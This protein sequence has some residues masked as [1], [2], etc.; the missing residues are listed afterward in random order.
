MKVILSSEVPRENVLSGM[1]E[2]GATPS[3]AWLRDPRRRTG[4]DA[5][6]RAGDVRLD[7][8]DGYIDRHMP[9]ASPAVS[10]TTDPPTPRPP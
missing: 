5:G 1:P 7:G 10:E 3:S 8:P 6:F 4:A 9:E 2:T